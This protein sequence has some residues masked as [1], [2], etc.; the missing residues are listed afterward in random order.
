[1]NK[2]SDTSRRTTGRMKSM[3]DESDRLTN[4]IKLSD[5]IISLGS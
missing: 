5:E 2:N 4:T 1:M 3:V